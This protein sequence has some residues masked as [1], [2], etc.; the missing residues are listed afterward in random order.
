MRTKGS[1]RSCTSARRSGSAERMQSTFAYSIR[2]CT[3]EDAATIARHRVE[4]FRAMGDVPTDLLA[5][6]LWNASAASVRTGLNQ[7]WY[8][9]WFAVAGG[10]VIGGA[11]VHV[12]N[13][14]PRIASDGNSVST[15]NVQLVV[16]V[17]T[18][19]A[20]RG[21]GVARALMRTIM[22]W[23]V[24]Q[25][26]DRVVLHASVAGRSLYTSLGFIQTN[27]MRW[28]PSRVR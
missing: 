5:D 3:P 11:G 18:E 14:L 24:T 16:N 8:L 13:Q 1:T 10:E 9:G 4:M 6:A 25:K 2:T 28:T 20:W 21:R 12:R 23:A 15:A 17:F 22:D 27:E 7:G 19:P 26:F